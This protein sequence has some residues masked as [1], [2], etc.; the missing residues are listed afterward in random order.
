MITEFRHIVALIKTMEA[1]V[2]NLVRTC[3]SLKKENEELKQKLAEYDKC[4]TDVNK[5]TQEVSNP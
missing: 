2:E 5:S 4:K 1:N 3:D